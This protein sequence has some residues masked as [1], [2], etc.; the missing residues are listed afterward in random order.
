MCADGVGGVDKQRLDLTK[1]G[2]YLHFLIVVVHVYLGDTLQSD[3]CSS[4][5]SCLT[6]CLMRITNS[7][8]EEIDTPLFSLTQ[9]TT[10]LQAKGGQR[11]S[12]KFCCFITERAASIFSL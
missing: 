5:N 10:L 9:G 3:R 7:D 11:T 8:A 4:T 6:G 2:F 1:L 12:H